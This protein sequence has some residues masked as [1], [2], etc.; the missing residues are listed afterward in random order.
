MTHLWSES[1]R[2]VE[3]LPFASLHY[4]F[5]LAKQD[6]CQGSMGF[7]WLWHVWRC[8]SESRFCVCVCVWE[9]EKETIDAPQGS[10]QLESAEVLHR[11]DVGKLG[12]NKGHDVHACALQGS[13]YKTQAYLC[14]SCCIHTACI[15]INANFYY[16]I[17]FINTNILYIYFLFSFMYIIKDCVTRSMVKEKRKIWML[18][19]IIFSFVPLS[20]YCF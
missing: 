10:Y 17:I 16:R 13:F 2:P 5:W 11:G 8:L 14:P 4:W 3:C 18:I 12:W 9:T 15:E 19:E 6:L 7:P 20:N 1:N